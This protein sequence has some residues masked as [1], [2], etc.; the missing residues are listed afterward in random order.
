[1]LRLMIRLGIHGKRH[2]I[3]EQKLLQ[4]MHEQGLGA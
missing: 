1:M 2:R 3:A 4:W